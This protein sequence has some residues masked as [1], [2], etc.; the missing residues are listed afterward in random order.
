MTSV[1]L[2]LRNSTTRTNQGRLYIQIIHNRQ[3]K[4]ITTNFKL[5]QDEWDKQN[6]KIIPDLNNLTRLIE[7][8][9]MEMKIRETLQDVELIITKLKRKKTFTVNDIYIN[10]YQISS[11]NML[12]VFIKK[13]IRELNKS[14]RTNTACKYEITLRHLTSFRQGHDIDFDE[15]SAQIIKDFETFLI[16]RHITMN[17][18]SFY[19]RIVRTIYNKAIIAG[20]A[21]E[22]NLFR[23]V[24]TGIAKTTKRAINHDVIQ[25]LR[26]V[27]L[28]NHLQFTRDMFMF[29]FYTRGMSFI[30]MAQL[31]KRDCTNGV[32]I[33]TRSKTKQVLKIKL[34]PCITEIINRYTADTECF[35]NLLPI[36]VSGNKKRSYTSAIQT[37]NRNLKTLSDLLHIAPVLTSYV[38]R[39]TWASQ[40]RRKGINLSI[41]SEGMGHTSEK[42]TLIYL[43]SIEQHTLDDANR[44][45][46]SE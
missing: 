34:E 42:T 36:T 22:K 18:V 6:H 15:M 32:L 28:T 45:I 46:I 16:A 2:K 1:K 24:Y 5:F 7:L 8:C 38:S 11:G 40:A 19:L 43:S 4:I 10:Y 26:S 35:D 23:T 20:M 9:N 37:Y 29:S 14:G 13:L 44:L 31:K 17:T 27:E 12:F 39:H 25:T 30:D 33:Y 41:I 3:V 21:P